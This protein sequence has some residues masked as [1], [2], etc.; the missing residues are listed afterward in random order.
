M[1]SVLLKS[2]QEQS[3]FHPAKENCFINKSCPNQMISTVHSWGPGQAKQL[4]LYLKKG[5]VGVGCSSH[6]EVSVVQVFL[7]E[8]SGGSGYHVSCWGCSQTALLSLLLSC[9]AVAGMQLDWSA[10]SS[11][12]TAPVLFWVHNRELAYGTCYTVYEEQWWRPPAYTREA[13]TTN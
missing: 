8:N 5:Y 9:P 11:A 1:C 2:H 6:A 4:S 10:C 12:R 3:V 7:S 13:E